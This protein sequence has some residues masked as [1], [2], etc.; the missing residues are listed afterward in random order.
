[1]NRR[2]I[3]AALGGAALTTVPAQAARA[4]EPRRA[5]AGAVTTDDLMRIALDLAGYREIPAD[6]AIHHPTSGIRRLV[7]A[8]DVDTGTLLFAKQAGYDC[9]ISHHP[10]EQLPAQAI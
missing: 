4:L 2:E 3:L 10:M 6:S 8:L 7:F 5:V 9:V 1:M